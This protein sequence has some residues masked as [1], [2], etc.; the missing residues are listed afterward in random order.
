MVKS[1]EQVVA[2]QE[3]IRKQNWFEENKE[4]Y[5]SIRPSRDVDPFYSELC[6]I[7]FDWGSHEKKKG[8]GG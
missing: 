3:L 4:G 8:R 1:F 5:Y 2:V 7:L 6:E